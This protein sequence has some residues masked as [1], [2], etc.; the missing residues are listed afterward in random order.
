MT[1]LQAWDGAETAERI[2]RGDVSPREVVE[3]AIRRAE[4][5]RSLGALVT[6]TFQRA[7]DRTAHPFPSAAPFAGVPSA[8]KDLTNV[9]GVPTRWGS[10]GGSTVPRPRSDPVVSVFEGLGLVSL[11]KTATPELG[12]TATTEPLGFAPC[13]NPWDVTRTPGGSSGGSAVLVASGVVPLAAASDGGGS[14]RIPAAC[15]GLVGLKPTRGRLD[16]EGS[17]LLPVNIAVHGVVSRTV[18]DTV[19]FWEAVENAVPSR[20]PRIGPVASAPPTPLRIGV[21]TNSP[22]EYEVAASHRATVEAVARQCEALGHH[23]EVLS[24]PIPAEFLDD[25]L[26][27]W[28]FVAF[29]QTRGMRW[30]TQRD[31]DE[32]QYEPWSLAMA[33]RFA[34]RPRAGLAAMWRVRGFGARFVPVFSRFDV[35]LMPTTAHAPPVLG[36]LAPDLPFETKRARLRQF[37]PFTAAFNASG[38]PALSLPLG[39]DEA[40]L[41]VGVQLGANL[42]QECTLLELARQL[43]AAMPWPPQAPTP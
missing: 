13:R 11:G 19:A 14:I 27:Y 1:E 3:A 10:R 17:N 31:F 21:S 30:L 37:V 16:M 23:V 9:E 22:L 28:S 25:F 12:L 39:R 5:T 41:P 38:C 42:G 34:S 35:L 29:A 7:L 20:W 2:R 4:A 24:N 33:E 18:R 15:C 40:G 32:R 6:E 36:T 26:E 43:E 8:I